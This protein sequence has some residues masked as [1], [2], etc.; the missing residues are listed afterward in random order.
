MY[1]YLIMASDVQKSE[2]LQYKIRSRWT[3]WF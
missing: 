1:W 3:G 2:K